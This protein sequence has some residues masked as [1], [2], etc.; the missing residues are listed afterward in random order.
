MGENFDP[1]APLLGLSPASSPRSPNLE[2]KW[3]E[4][5]DP[6]WGECEQRVLVMSSRIIFLSSALEIG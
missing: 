6:C 2:G 3:T 5:F 4:P 1:I